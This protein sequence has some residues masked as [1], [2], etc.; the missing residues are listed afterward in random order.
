MKLTDFSI[1]LISKF[2]QY[3]N[4]NFA[5]FMYFGKTRF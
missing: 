5:S 1:E 4:D 2:K 3:K